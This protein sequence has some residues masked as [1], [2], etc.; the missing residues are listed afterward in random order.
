MK[1]KIPYLILALII[2]AAQPASAVLVFMFDPGP[3]GTTIITV[4]GDSATA[5]GSGGTTEAEQIGFSAQ[6]SGTVR[7]RGFRVRADSFDYATFASLGSGNL[8]DTISL[9]STGITGGSPTLIDSFFFDSNEFYPLVMDGLANNGDTLS[10][11]DSPDTYGVMPVDFTAFQSLYN[12][13]LVKSDG[14]EF[15]FAP[16]PS[17]TALLGLGLSSLLLRR[18]RS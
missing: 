2:C 1:T 8:T 9:S 16:E 12:T 10:F 18:R 6:G 5:G 7:Q 17:S 3:S 13:T 15:V 4:S 11:A 14:I